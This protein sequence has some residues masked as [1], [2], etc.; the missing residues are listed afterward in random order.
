MNGQRNRI[1]YL[2]IMILY[3]ICLVSGCRIGLRKGVDAG[4]IFFY[5]KGGGL[6]QADKDNYLKLDARGETERAAIVLNGQEQE[7]ELCWKDDEVKITYADGTVTEGTWGNDCLLDKEGMPVVF[8]GEA[9]AVTAG[10]EAEELRKEVLSDALCRISRGVLKARGSVW[11][12]L[13]GTVFYG[14]GVFAVVNPERSFFFL[15]RWRYREA[16]LSPEG[17]AVEQIGGAVFLAAGAVLVS[18]VFL[19]I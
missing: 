16:E 19:L 11:F 18:G 7:A 4:D 10:G 2:I 17:K 12:M 3:V 13:L 14:L 1:F 15:N 6:Y 9:V 8:S 5:K